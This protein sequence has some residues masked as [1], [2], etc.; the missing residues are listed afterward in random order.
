HDFGVSAA[1]LSDAQAARLAAVLPNPKDRSASRPSDYVRR[2]A[3]QVRDGAATI[4]R[5]GRA[6]C[7][8]S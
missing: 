1:E 4:R 8:E 7:F 2:R 3:A 5:D 6:A